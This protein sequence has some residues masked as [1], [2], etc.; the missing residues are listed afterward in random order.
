MS[1]RVGQFINWVQQNT[2]S[3]SNGLPHEIKT[4]PTFKNRTKSVSFE[5]SRENVT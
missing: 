5:V 2:V 4:G 1:S 3:F